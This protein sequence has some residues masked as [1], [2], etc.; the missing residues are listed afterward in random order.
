VTVASQ[1]TGVIQEIGNKVRFGLTEFLG[2]DGAYV[3]VPIGSRQ[4]KPWNQPTAAVT[5]YASNKAAIVHAIEATNNEGNTPLAEALYE[6]LR[7]IAQVG[8]SFTSTQYRHPFA[9]SPAVALGTNGAGSLGGTV[10]NLE[11]KVLTGT[12]TCP[13]TLPPPYTAQPISYVTDA[14]GRDPFFYGSEHDVSE[15]TG[16]AEPSALVLC[17]KTFIIISTDGEPTQDTSVPAAIQNFAGSISGTPCV[18]GSATIHPPNGTC[19][20]NQNT[21]PNIL[22]GEHKT[23]YS[24]SGT[25]YLNDVAYWGHIRD[26]RQATIPDI[27]VAGQDLPG[28]Q[29]VTI[30]SFFTFGNIAGRE[31]L[32][33]TAQQGGFDDKNGNTIPDTGEWDT[34]INSGPLSGS[35]GSD[36]IPDTFFESADAGEIKD[37]LTE[38]FTSILQRSSAGTSLSVLATSSNG[39][40]A[41]YQSYFYPEYLDPDPLKPAVRWIGFTHGLFVDTFGNIRE[42]TNTDNR[43]RYKQD[44]IIK[45]R[46]DSNTNTLL[47]D[48][49]ND[50]DG[51]GLPDDTSTPKDGIPD[52]SPCGQ[53]IDTLSP[54][55]EAG[56]RLALTSPADRR[57][58]TWLD[59]NA[60]AWNGVVDAGEQISFELSNCSNLKEYLRQPADPCDGSGNGSAEKIIKFIRGE[61]VSGMRNRLLTLG[62]IGAGQ[63]VWKLGDPI[64][65]TPTEVGPPQERYDVIYGDASYGKFYR[66]WRDRRRVIYMGAN[67]GMLHAFNGG[68]YHRGDDPSTTGPDDV[69]RGWFTTTAVSGT[70]GAN[71]GDELWAFIPMQLLPHLTWLTQPNYSHVYYVDLKPKVTE[72]KI[73]TEEAQC[74]PDPLNAACK[75]PGGWGTILI[76]GFRMGGS[77][78]NC[79]AGT[80]APPMQATIGGVS[81]TFYSAYFVLDITDSESD[82]KLLWVFTDSGLGLTTS[83]PAVLRVNPAYPEPKVGSGNE[84]WFMLV[85]S[86]PNSYA[87]DLPSVPVQTPKV[88]AINLQTGPTAGNWKSFPIESASGWRGFVG[89][90]ITFDR[91]LD[92]RVD[93]AYFGSTLHDGALPWRGKLYRLTMGDTFPFGSQTSLDN[94]G[95]ASGGNR[96]PTEILDTF[97]IPCTA[98]CTS[99]RELGPVTTAPGVTLDDANNVWV[100]A[101]TGR[102]YSMV[103]KTNAD[104]QYFVGIKDSVMFGPVAVGGCS[105]SNAT[106]CLRND[107]LNVTNVTVCELGVGGCTQSSQVTGLASGTS[108]E[109][110]ATS[111]VGQVQA[112]HGWV[113]ELTRS[114]ERVIAKP[115]V[116]GG[117]IFFPSFVPENDVCGISGDSYLFG[118]FY[119]T[120]SAYK[121]SVIGT[122]SG[123][124]NK[125][126]FLDKGV[127][128]AVAV[129]IGSQAPGGNP[130]AVK[131]CIQSSSAAVTCVSMSPPESVAS[132]Y[133][134]WS[135]QRD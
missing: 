60:P 112:K 115:I 71:L 86:G 66:K 12:E 56:K 37:R 127:A 21:P 133:V 1:P 81:R 51:N 98:P 48:Y 102:Y 78:G 65:S 22:L 19:N 29:N 131:G 80:G 92:Y 31:L 104:T 96:I 129:H 100:F 95:I 99:T 114:R 53:T 117:V 90:I 122:T 61:Q 73:F 11:M 83:Y 116:L 82:P 67:D 5:T 103:D 64:H 20:T 17:C 88:Y 40:G 85:G 43:L 109:N 58:L 38:V 91:D 121:S 97:N 23:D 50:A 72:A 2:N 15:A 9:F 57:I 32:M 125:S 87:A 77:C 70:R 49:Y 39:E 62:A 41:L 44:R 79:A 36:G 47:L 28:K 84:R 108:F 35:A 134:T 107:L 46:F 54:I 7:Y 45:T 3:M 69:E 119:K 30:Y 13:T 14:C 132:R 123:T 135:R 26:L 55:W 68:V 74:S 42:D 8:S 120:G 52:C 16:W 59:S 76:G 34:V 93:A 75:H 111:L 124:I 101:G 6:S 106:S 27:G 130:S 110:G 25:H 10:G 128:S 126:V 94:W 63:N 24:S 4:V 105:Q 18:G 33:H 118:L 113:T 89:E